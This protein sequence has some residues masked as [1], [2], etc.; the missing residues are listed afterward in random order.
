MQA[1][2]KLHPTRFSTAS[3]RAL[4]LAVTVLGLLMVPSVAHALLLIT[5]PAGTTQAAY[6]PGLTNTPRLI[7]A[8]GQELSGLCTGVG[9]P[10]GVSSFTTTFTGE[11]TA[12][13]TTLLT[14]SEGD[15]TFVWNNGAT[16]TWHFTATV[17]TSVGGQ[18]VTT[19]QGP[20]T[21]GLFQGAQVT[22]VVTLLNLDLA[23]CSTEEGLTS[24]SGTSTYLFTAL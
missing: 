4:L 9:L 17:G 2:L 21:S 13:C 18:R 7:H 3:P 1:S 14:A 15:Q 6:S 23:A 8:V 20:I 5:C 24:A 19:L 10:M 11:D 16:S 12:A 22:Q